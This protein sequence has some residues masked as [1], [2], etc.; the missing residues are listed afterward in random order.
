MFNE[1]RYILVIEDSP[2][3]QLLLTRAIGKSQPSPDILMLNDGEEALE[4]IRVFTRVPDLILLDIKIPKH[5]GHEVL[6]AFKASERFRDVPVIVM[7]T[8]TMHSDIA[9]AYRL[10]ASSYLV[11]NASTA[12]WNKEL[13]LAINYWLNINRTVNSKDVA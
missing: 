13:N 12:E 1:N 2:D 9:K 5:D 3:D 7:T 4:F 6:M 10:G 8:S 11:K